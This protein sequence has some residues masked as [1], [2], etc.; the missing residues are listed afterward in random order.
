MEGVKSRWVSIRVVRD[1]SRGQGVGG[2]AV[3]LELSWSNH[4]VT[5]PFNDTPIWAPLCQHYD[6]YKCYILSTLSNIKLRQPQNL[7]SWELIPNPESRPRRG[8][9]ASKAKFSFRKVWQVI[10]LTSFGSS[11]SPYCI[12]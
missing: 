11:S 5:T 12:V 10:M 7:Q 3:E 2:S 8:H 1:I 9:G 4:T 6:E